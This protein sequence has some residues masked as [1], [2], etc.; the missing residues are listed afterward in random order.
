M[1][2]RLVS[3]ITLVFHAKAVGSR[4]RE[5]LVVKEIPVAAV[6]KKVA[7]DALLDVINQ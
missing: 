4:K 3:Q 2:A 1:R 7:P 5:L 6:A